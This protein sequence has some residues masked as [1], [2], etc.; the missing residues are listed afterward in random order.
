MKQDYVSIVWQKSCDQRL[1]RNLT[2]ILRVLAT[3]HSG[4]LSAGWG[5]LQEALA[6]PSQS[7][8]PQPISSTWGT[9]GGCWWRDYQWLRLLHGSVR[10]NSRADTACACSPELDLLYSASLLLCSGSFWSDTP[11]FHFKCSKAP[12]LITSSLAPSGCN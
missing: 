2:E 3:Q 9:L 11:F 5:A 8:Q 7:T 4:G 6:S 10:M 12:V 1:G